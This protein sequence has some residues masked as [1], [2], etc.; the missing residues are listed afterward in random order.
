[1]GCRPDLRPP[2]QQVGDL[3]DLSRLTREEPLDPQ[4]LVHD[5]DRAGDVRRMV[6]MAMF[7]VDRTWRS[8]RSVYWMTFSKRLVRIPITSQGRGTCGHHF[9]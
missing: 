9:K 6:R 7:E 1:M 2:S 8:S 3:S 5:I 4:T